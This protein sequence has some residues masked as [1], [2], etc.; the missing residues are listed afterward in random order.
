MYPHLGKKKTLSQTSFFNDPKALFRFR[1]CNHKFRIETGHHS[2]IPHDDRI[3]TYCLQKFNIRVVECEYHVFFH[4]PKHDVILLRQ[5]Y[6]FNWYK[7]GTDVN[8]FY[9][10]LQIEKFEQLRK[11]AY[12]VCMILTC[13]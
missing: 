10:I 12:Y 5:H 2:N 8:S 1:C 9:E 3:C 4:C 13:D 6:L 7:R 11:L